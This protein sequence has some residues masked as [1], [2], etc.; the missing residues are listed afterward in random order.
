[1]SSLKA[2]PK[3]QL[4]PTPANNHH[5]M[6]DLRFCSQSLKLPN[7]WEKQE[8]GDNT[9]ATALF[10]KEWHEPEEATAVTKKLST[11]RSSALDMLYLCRK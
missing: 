9:A 1:M 3:N 11:A 10:I 6:T 8:C 4:S 7:I 5:P 2:V